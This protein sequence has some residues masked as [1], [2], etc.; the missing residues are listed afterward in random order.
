MIEIELIR[1]TR[2]DFGWR[3]RVNDISESE[4]IDSVLSKIKKFHGKL[5]REYGDDIE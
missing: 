4:S 3:V 5:N 2:G 1:G